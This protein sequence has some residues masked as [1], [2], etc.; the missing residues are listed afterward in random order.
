MVDTDT[1]N[2]LTKGNCVRQQLHIWENL[3]EM[4][5]QLQKCL[6]TANKLPQASTFAPLKDTHKNEIDA[7]KQSVRNLLD[8]FLY[9]Q[10]LL[11]NRYPETKNLMK[12]EINNK[13]QDEDDEEI[14]SDSEEETPEIPLKKRKYNDL[15]L[16][17]VKRHTQYKSYR[18]SVIQK[19][20]D[21][22]RIASNKTTTPVHSVIN[23]IDHILSDKD[24]LI[25]KTQLKK[26]D[27]EII[28]A[29][30]SN[31]N[32]EEYNTEIFDDTDFY[33]HLLRELIE[34]KS[35]DVTDPVQLGR[36]W[37]HLQNLRSKMKRKMDTKATKGRKIRYTV[38]SKLVNFMA[39]VE[40]ISWQ[41]EAKTELFNSLFGKNQSTNSV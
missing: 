24:K 7:T 26:T 4:R 30:E 3:L 11:W 16:E 28:G 17:I 33:H 13:P 14:Q 20:N 40:D 9:L 25:K 21:K 32:S 8:K 38:H 31:S 22:T 2:E 23:Q 10:S 15:G 6:I 37:I 36:Q 5:I 29:S 18:N 39:P 34:Y 1:L 19:W 41:N 35:S 27:Y 12:D